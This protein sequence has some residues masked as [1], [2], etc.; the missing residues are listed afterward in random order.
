MVW[1]GNIEQWY[2][3][4]L[5]VQ[6]SMRPLIWNIHIHIAFCDKSFECNEDKH[7]F[8][9]CPE[10]HVST[11]LNIHSSQCSFLRQILWVHQTRAHSFDVCPELHVSTDL[12]RH[13]RIAN[14]LSRLK[15]SLGLPPF[16]PAFLVGQTRFFSKGNKKV[17]RRWQ[18]EQEIHSSSLPLSQSASLPVYLSLSL[19]LSQSVVPSLCRSLSL[20]LSLSVSLSVS[21]CLIFLME[22]SL[23][24]PFILIGRSLSKRGFGQD[25]FETNPWAQH[26]K[27][28]KIWTLFS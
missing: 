24:L 5:C 9:V 8:V 12:N 4:L 15:R 18:S 11:D 6:L 17:K 26:R 22:I 16:S 20:L 3:I 14:S 23:D 13:T 19:P 25:T 7:C 27:L 1:P 28:P 10:L 21:G 2:I